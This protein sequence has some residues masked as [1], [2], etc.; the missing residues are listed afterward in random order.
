MTS[1]NKAAAFSEKAGSI[2]EQI[3]LAQEKLSRLQQKRK[4]EIGDIALKS[5]LS[6]I[7]NKKLLIEFQSIAKKLSYAKPHQTIEKTTA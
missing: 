2:E 6:D 5:G 7:D 1:Q 4:L 3:K